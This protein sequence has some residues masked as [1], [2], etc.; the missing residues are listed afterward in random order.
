MISRRSTTVKNIAGTRRSKL[1]AHVR[2]TIDT[3]SRSFSKFV[4]PSKRD[5]GWNEEGE[6]TEAF[7]YTR[8]KTIESKEADKHKMTDT[9]RINVSTNIG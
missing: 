8:R 9:K 4:F 3:L 7:A 6:N 5:N 2:N 1:R